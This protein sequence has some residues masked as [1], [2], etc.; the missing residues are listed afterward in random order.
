VRQLTYADRELLLQTFDSLKDAWH[1]SD[2]QLLA[3]ACEFARRLAP[4]FGFEHALTRDIAVLS[5]YLVQHKADKD[6][7]EIARGGLLYVVRA[8]QHGPTKLGEFGL[9]DDA[10][11][12]SYAV[13]EIRTRLGEQATYNPPQLTRS[14]QGRAENLF[15]EFAEKPF[16]ED[17]KLVEESRKVGNYLAG[18]ATCGLFRRLQKNI[19][20]LISVLYDSGRTPE[21]RSYARAALSYVVCEADAID[22]RLGIVGYLND[23][24]IAQTAVD[25]IEPT[26]EPWLELL[27]ATV[28]AWPFLNGLIIDDGSGGRPLSEYLIINSALSCKDLRGDENPLATVLVTPLTGPVPFILGFVAALG[29][30][31][32]S[33]QLEISEDSFRPGQKVRVDAFDVAEFDGFETREGRRMFRLRQYYTERGERLSRVRSWPISDLRRLVPANWALP[34]RGQLTY[35]LNSSDAPLPGLDCLFSSDKTV[36]LLAV[37]KHVVVVMSIPVADVYEMAQQLQFQGHRLKDMIPMGHLTVDKGIRPWSNRFGKQQPLLVF[38]ADLD[39][40]LQFADEKPEANGL[41]IVDASGRN[42]HKTAS[43]RRLQQLKIRTLVVSTE[44]VANELDLSNKDHVGL[45]EWSSDDFASLLWPEQ[46]TTDRTG[47]I[48][49]YERRLQLQLVRTPEIKNLPMPLARQAFDAVNKVRECAHARGD[50]SLAELDDIVALSLSLMS[51]LLRSATPLTAD[52]PSTK[53]IDHGLCQLGEIRDR[54]LYLSEAER[55]AISCAENSL[56]GLLVELKHANLKANLL[57]ELLLVQSGLTIICPD[58]RLYADLGV[59]YSNTNTRVLYHCEDDDGNLSGAIVPGWFGKERMA[60]LLVPPVTSP[61]HLVLYDVEQEWYNAF[62]RER[63]RSRDTRKV[64]S[65]RARV[66]PKVEG[67]GRPVA[68]HADATDTGRD[69]SLQELEAIHQYVNLS[70]RH[71]VYNASRSDGSEA[72]VSARLVMFE[73]DTYALLTDSYRANVVTHLLDSSVEDLD[74]EADIKRLLARQL[75]VGD[76]LLFHRGSARDVIRIAADKILGPGVRKTSSLW[77]EALLGYAAHEGLTAEAL[78]ER[79]RVAG[80]PLQYQ[81]IRNWLETDDTIAPQAYKRDVGLIAKLTRDESL[82]KHMND[83]L[84]AINEVRS[85][86]LQASR[87]LARQVIAKTVAMLREERAF[88]PLVEIESDVVVV[89]VAAVDEQLTQVRQS[90]VNQLLEGEQWHE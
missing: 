8:L 88:S 2:Q 69:T 43:L 18:L 59:A 57:R 83:V 47:P 15:L 23:N 64:H 63:R 81:T 38:A 16:L 32:E 68:E 34:T 25:L 46:T 70:Y 37:K 54:S 89:R 66:F 12:S 76:A 85:A 39:L 45:W 58:K 84:M 31:H 48:V 82:T 62:R 49:R 22:N 50:E 21:Q 9:L 19:D 13:H 40:A 42:A 36:H 87:Q 86:H 24:F 10:F 5:R 11:V 77:R 72:E 27:D 55:S 6:L 90:L 79:L 44:R 35:D 29:L 1:G 17:G 7:T 53:E 73:G 26:R 28:G 30:V 71:R 4:S 80:C 67:W 74:D 51:R 14:E 61:M 78:W 65:S 20:F 75:S 56:R 3:E 33:E 52:I 41:V 60:T